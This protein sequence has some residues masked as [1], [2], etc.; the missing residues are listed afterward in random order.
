MHNPD[1]PQC[2]PSP[3]STLFGGK[4]FGKP[5]FNVMSLILKFI[6][7]VLKNDNAPFLLAPRIFTYFL[8]E[9]I[10]R[11]QEQF[12]IIVFF[13]ITIIINIIM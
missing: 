11:T 6:I 2:H 13:I 5:P 7:I 9:G 3:T 12:K 10:Q 4:S 1:D 8:S